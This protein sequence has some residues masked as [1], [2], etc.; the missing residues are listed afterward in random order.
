MKRYTYK[1]LEAEVSY[2]NDQM[3]AAGIEWVLVP[4]QR[5]NYTAIDLATPEQAAHYCV[6]ELLETGTPKEC[7]AKA[8]QF[9]AQQFIKLHNL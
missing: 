7:I 4:G 8:Q 2:L 6:H 1:N 3:K 5:C 9:V